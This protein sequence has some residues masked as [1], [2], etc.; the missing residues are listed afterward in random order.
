MKAGCGSSSLRTQRRV[1]YT[2]GERKHG[3]ALPIIAEA[4]EGLTKR[5]VTL[6]CRRQMFDFEKCPIYDVAELNEWPWWVSRPFECQG[7]WRTSL[8]HY[9][10]RCQH[11]FWDVPQ[12]FE[13]VPNHELGQDDWAESKQTGGYFACIS[14]IMQS[15]RDNYY[16]NNKP[17]CK[18]GCLKIFSNLCVSWNCVSGFNWWIS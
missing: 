16:E 13:M 2:T 7:R 18:I 5:Y 17:G 14:L 9:P 8:H 1:E 12:H 10:T 6:A 3:E 4:C 11:K 15:Q